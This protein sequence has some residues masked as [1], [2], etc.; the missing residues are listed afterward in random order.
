MQNRTIDNIIETIINGKIPVR[1]NQQNEE[2]Q[3]LD[4]KTV[5]PR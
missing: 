2:R 3:L 1:K 5:F 4:K